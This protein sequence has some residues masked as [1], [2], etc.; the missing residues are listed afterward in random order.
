MKFTS[1]VL[2]GVAAGLVQSTPVEKR[3]GVSDGMSCSIDQSMNIHTDHC[4]LMSST[5]L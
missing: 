5:T 1:S 3:A 4:Q 2:L